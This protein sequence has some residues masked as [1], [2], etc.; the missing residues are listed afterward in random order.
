MH[1]QTAAVTPD[2]NDYN[3]RTV[4]GN[5]SENNRKHVVFDGI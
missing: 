5:K 2:Y 1:P 3:H 4:F